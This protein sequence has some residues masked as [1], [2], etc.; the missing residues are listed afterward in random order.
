[1]TIDDIAK[2]FMGVDIQYRRTGFD[3]I[4][5][6]W[7]IATQPWRARVVT[8]KNENAEYRR[9]VYARTR[10]DVELALVAMVQ[11]ADRGEPYR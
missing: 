1:M 10:A 9:T 4:G 5:G 11:A 7:S 8:S 6:K 2:R 3:S